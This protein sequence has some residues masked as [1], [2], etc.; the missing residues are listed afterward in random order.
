M[1][2][3]AQLAHSR[4]TSSSTLRRSLFIDAGHQRLKVEPDG[5]VSYLHSTEFGK[6][7]FGRG[8][9]EAYKIQAGVVIPLRQRDRRLRISPGVIGL[10]SMPQEPMQTSQTIRLC[11]RDSSGYLRLIR[12]TNRS[13]AGVRL[14]VLTLHDPTTLNFRAENDPPS[15]IGVNAFNRG[16]HVVMD[17]AGDTT[18]VRVIGFAPRPTVVYLTRVKQK[19]V[20]FVATGEVPVNT[21]GMSGPII[22]LSQHD[23]ELPPGSS[24]DLTVASLYHG[25]SLES[26]LS[27]LKDSYAAAGE[28][29][30]ATRGPTF[31]CSSASVNFAFAWAKGSLG[32]IERVPRSIDRIT[33]GFGLGVLRPAIFEGEFGA[34]KA[35]Q[36]RDGFLPHSNSDRGGPMETSLFVINSCSYLGLRGD[37]KLARKWYPALRR[38]GNALRSAAG[39][40]LIATPPGSPDGWRRRL[41]SGYPTGRVTEVNMV[42]ARALS[43]LAALS[44]AINKSAES[45]VFSDASV[46]D[47]QGGGRAAE[48]YRDGEPRSQ[49]RPEG[50]A[51]FGGDRRPG[52]GAL[53]LGGR[54]QARTVRRAQ[55]PGERLRDGLRAKDGLADERPVLQSVIRRRPARRVLDA[56]ARSP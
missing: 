49:P 5:S 34:S 28:V 36:N 26:A 18:G 52:R 35:S 41:G 27:G 9:V 8:S 19:A 44:G 37:R 40:G 11:G 16:D 54:D 46:Q 3:E 38:A 55:A 48:G 53:V 45:A 10:S 50:E 43:D 2:Q 13:E 24:F 25:S 20:D 39:D 15:D 56:A 1:Q 22:I 23:A 33:A 51:P 47:P 7:L 6:I 29:V 12:Y 32:S 14:R 30:G 42:A 31:A 21:A 17:D 4:E